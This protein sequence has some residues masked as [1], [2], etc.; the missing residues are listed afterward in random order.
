METANCKN[1]TLSDSP[2]TSYRPRHAESKLRSLAEF[3]KVVLVTG[4][5]QV[6]KSTLLAHVFPEY[7]SVVFDP[8][9]D[10][11][12]A[13]QDPDLF[14]DNFP[15][16]LIL[17]EIQYAPEL[18]PA[19]KRRVDGV[20][21]PG[22]YLL[23]GSQNLAVL[24]T[25]AESMAGRVGIL[26][27]QGLTSEEILG[28]GEERGWLADFLEAPES[29]L[30]RK[31]GHRSPISTPVQR[32]WRGMMPGLLDAP[33]SIVPDYFRSYIQTYVDRD[34]RTMEDVRQLAEFGRF[35]GLAAALTSQ[36][37]NASQLGRE[38]GVSPS[39]ARRWLDLLTHTYQWRQIAP[40][41]GNTIKRLTGKSKG[42][43]SDTGLASYLQRLSS[44]QALAVSPLLGPLFESYVVQEIH[45][46][47]VQLR[48][49]PL[50][51]HWRT[52]G[53]AEVDLVLERDGRL[54]PIEIK[55]KTQLSGHDTRGLRAFRETYP[56][57][58]IATGLIVYAGDRTYRLNQDTIALPWDATRG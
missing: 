37:I 14:L 39:T 29:L 21:D 42:Y 25:V 50:A 43:L 12:G 20:G 38:V 44:P 5:R 52:A 53:G 24:R 48:T 57:Q 31:R 11:Y 41:H 6:G 27:L 55:C 19:I 47:F 45:G 33:D 58:D 8:I 40:Y 46:Q 1:M 2:L 36:E 22:Q 7:Q 51:H 16:P 30:D 3:F 28:C 49:P 13:R 17:D 34:I 54:H 9:Q 32:V 23:T 56:G 18:L 15:P 4:A 10:L 35:L 26:S